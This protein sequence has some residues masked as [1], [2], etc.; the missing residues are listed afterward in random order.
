MPLLYQVCT[1]TGFPIRDADGD[2]GHLPLRSASITKGSQQR[3][4]RPGSSSCDREDDGH[5]SCTCIALYPI[6]YCTVRNDGDD[7]WDQ[8]RAQ[9]HPP[10]AFSQQGRYDPNYTQSCQSLAPPYLPYQIQLRPQFSS[11]LLVLLF[12]NFRPPPLLRP[13]PS[14]HPALA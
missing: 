10:D 8:T 7:L 14:R 13:P 9:I 4:E 11:P 1:V 3:T 2:C 12:A 6:R 5:K